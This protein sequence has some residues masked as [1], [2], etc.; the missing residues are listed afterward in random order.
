MS[1]FISCTQ[2][3]CRNSE[4]TNYAN[5]PYLLTFFKDYSWHAYESTFV[6]VPLYF[7][8]LPEA[9]G[10]WWKETSQI[11]AAHD[12][13][14]RVSVI[15]SLLKHF[16]VNSRFCHNTTLLPPQV[17]EGVEKSDVIT[18]NVWSET[19]K[20][21]PSLSGASYHSF[22]RPEAIPRSIQ[23]LSMDSN[24]D[25]SRHHFCMTKT[26]FFSKYSNSF[27]KENI[28]IVGAQLGNSVGAQRGPLFAWAPMHRF[29]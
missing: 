19:Y 21:Q 16:W 6:E 29:K 8:P 13:F 11:Q 17:W 20:S 4:A 15:V 28:T 18:P 10:K 26:S 1:P 5:S 24:S 22:E 12:R 2:P 25:E 3:T 7:H 9:E 14:V 23:V 27:N